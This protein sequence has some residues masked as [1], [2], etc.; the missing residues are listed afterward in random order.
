M[1]AITRKLLA[2]RCT[3]QFYRC[4]F[5]A[6]ASVRSVF[7][8]G[9]K[10]R[11]LGSSPLLLQNSLFLYL[12]SNFP[13]IFFIIPSTTAASRSSIVNLLSSLLSFSSDILLA[14]APT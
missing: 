2:C 13:T 9:L 6:V 3:V 8:G 7:E 1:V 11:V 12:F 14:L 5:L 10:R 4:G